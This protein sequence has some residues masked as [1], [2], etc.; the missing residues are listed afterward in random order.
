MKHHLDNLSEK[1]VLF[2]SFGLLKPN[3]VDAEIVQRK[4]TPDLIS[5]KKAIDALRTEGKH[6]L[7]M[8]GSYD[9]VHAGHAFYIYQAIDMYL[10]MPGNAHLSRKD[11]IVLVLADDD[12]LI[13]NV[14]AKKWKGLG[15]SEPFKRPIQSKESFGA[16]SADNHWRLVELASIPQVDLVGFIPSPLQAE[17]LSSKDIISTQKTSERLRSHLDEFKNRTTISENDFAKLEKALVDYDAIIQFLENNHAA[18]SE[19]F[20]TEGEAWSIQAW[21]LFLHMYL[22]YGEFKAP[23]VRIISHND[24]A[25]KDQVAFLM[26]V[27]GLEGVYIQDESLIS[28]TDLLAEHG[29]EV[30]IEA[31]LKNYL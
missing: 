16:R 13:S 7:Y 5:L 21:Q 26:E 22:G 31:K 29:H 25:Y 9:L 24:V 4:I 3:T 14:K 28:T 15:G 11:L 20:L 19:A 30:L 17:H 2:D 8:P 23:F 27:S 12:E 10:A 18:I 6:I 1:G